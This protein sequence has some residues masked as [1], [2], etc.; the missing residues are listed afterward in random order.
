MTD[1]PTRP[2]RFL[3]L[4]AVMFGIGGFTAAGGM[5]CGVLAAQPSCN[6]LITPGPTPDILD[7][8]RVDGPDTFA[9]REQSR[10]VMA[11]I[12]VTE[13]LNWRTYLSAR[14]SVRDDVTVRTAIFPD[15]E[16]R[17][18]TQARNVAAMR[19]SQ[20]AA[21][22]AAHRHVFGSAPH[23]RG[24]E[25]LAHTTKSVLTELP[26]GAV[27]TALNGVPITTV[28]ELDRRLAAVEDG[29]DVTLE[30]DTGRR[31]TVTK[32]TEKPV[33]GV[34]VAPAV[35]LP[36]A[37]A[38][39][40]GVVGG[41]SAGL[42][43]G[44]AITEQLTERSLIGALRV[45]GTGTLAPDGTVGAVGGIK[46]KLFAAGSFDSDVDVF[47]LPY[48]NRSQ[49]ARVTVERELAVVLV[50][51]LAD[52]LDALHQLNTGGTPN[53]MVTLRP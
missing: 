27:I 33:F 41:P 23:T 25:I 34:Y 31:V 7:N 15:G 47:L 2:T 30:T 13:R 43:F 18:D 36:F 22:Q 19:E 4:A 37:V 1:R 21:E 52:A 11:T 35:T 49:L 39:D 26:E 28:E 3:L 42:L 48:A 32:P 8:V 5:P 51:S 50:N 12:S 14:N 16:T 6:V 38:V 10:L 17:A 53:D 46:Q 29:A 45:S 40:A 44:V 20:R 24:V 9:P